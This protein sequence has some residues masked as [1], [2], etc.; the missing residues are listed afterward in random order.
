MLRVECGNVWLV[1][2]LLKQDNTFKIMLRHILVSATFVTIVAKFIKPPIHSVYTCQLHINK[3]IFLISVLTIKEILSL[4]LIKQ[5]CLIAKCS[6]GPV[7]KYHNPWC[8]W[9]VEVS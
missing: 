8:L 4:Y 7:R 9:L 3:S 6:R 2:K 5:R 1:V